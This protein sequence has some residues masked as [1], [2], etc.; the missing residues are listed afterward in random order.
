MAKNTSITLGNHFDTFITHQIKTGRYNSVSEVVR[1]GL[2]MLENN[3]TK[4]DS[5]RNLL[6]EGEK[7]G[8][9]EYS[10]E[11]LINTLDSETH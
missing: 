10:Y 3:E 1:A 8:F 5:L 9:A 2:R 6:K 11:K 7:S 4:L